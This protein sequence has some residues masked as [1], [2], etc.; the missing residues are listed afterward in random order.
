[1]TCFSGCENGNKTI[2]CFP[3][4]SINV[5]VDLNL[6]QFQNLASIG[7]WAYI[8]A[9]PLSGT[10]GLV[11]VRKNQNEFIVYDR[12]APHICPTNNSTLEVRSDIYLY[13]P[14]DGAKW[15]LSS[16]QP[17]EVSERPPKIY[18]SQFIGN[19]VYIAY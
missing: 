12:N 7:G 8:G 3:S 2:S 13:C 16:G 15:L 18:P 10:R 19:V 17:M 9:G 5:T 4:S 6:P 14:E 11:I 1:M